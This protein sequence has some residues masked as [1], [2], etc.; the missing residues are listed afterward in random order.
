MELQLM[1]GM[2]DTGVYCIP[3]CLA[4]ASRFASVRKIT[5]NRNELSI[6]FNLIGILSSS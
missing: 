2:A 4:G 3:S 5:S 1:T 6:S